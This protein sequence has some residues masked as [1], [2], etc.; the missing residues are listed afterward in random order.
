MMLCMNGDSIRC[1]VTF[2]GKR[3][4]STKNHFSGANALTHV[5]RERV[6]A[7]ANLTSPL[8]RTK[9]KLHAGTNISLSEIFNFQQVVY[10]FSQTGSHMK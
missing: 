7:I 4:V 1:I 8:H 10:M 6:W 3:L 2:P 9:S 5:T